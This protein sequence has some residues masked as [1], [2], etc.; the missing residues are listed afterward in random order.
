MAEHR[1]PR[2]AP[3]TALA[4]EATA[5]LNQLGEARLQV[6][7]QAPSGIQGGVR[8]LA[9]LTRFLQAYRDATLLPLELPWVL[10]AWQHAERFQPRELIELDATLGR[11]RWIQDLA[12]ASRHVGRSQLRLLKPLR[13]LR[14]VQRYQAA[15]DAGQA[16]GWHPV[17]YGVVLS[18][19]SIPLRTGLANYAQQTLHGFLRSSSRSLPISEES[20]RS[21]SQTLLAPVPERVNQVASGEAHAGL[22]LPAPPR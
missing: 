19:F 7:E 22:F 20:L 10:Q 3:T 2:I 11:H 17:V 8:D 6:V 12:T 15:V 13:D 4:G 14:L 18:V 5:L 1:S 21:L 16:Q 9:S